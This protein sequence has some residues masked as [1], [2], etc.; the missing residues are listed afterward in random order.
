MISGSLWKGILLF[1]L[2]LMA[3]NLLQVLFNISDIAV[4]GHFAGSKAL[5]EVGSTTTLVTLFLGI[6]LGLGNGVNVWVA[7]YLGSK[8]D[9][10]VSKTIHTA[11]II[12]LF[13][14]VLLSLVGILITNPLLELLNTKDSLIDGAASY[15]KIYLLAMPALA[16]YNFGNATYS[17]YGNTKS[18]LIILSLS[19]LLNVVL[20]IIFVVAFNLDVVGVSLASVISSYLS[21]AIILLSLFKEKGKIRI[22]LKNLKID[23]NIANKI[24]SVGIPASLQY[25]TF[26]VA[27]LFIQSGVNSFDDVFVEG[28]SAAANADSLVYDI[29]ASFYV[30]SSSFISQNFGAGNKDRIKKTYLITTIYSFGIG[31]ILGLLLVFF[32]KYFLMIFTLDKEVINE[33]YKRL[34]I[35]G[36]C[37]AFSALMDNTT[38]SCRGLGKTLFPSI[39]ILITSCLFRM[40]WVYTIFKI[41][42]TIESLYLVY[43]F[44]WLLSA[45]LEIP[46]F[47]YIYKK[48]TKNINNKMLLQ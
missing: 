45:L 20:N 28:N 29:M 16:L 10:M 37:Y 43:I 4:V 38:A 27:N 22:N 14:G 7:R 1:S 35:M 9:E 18:P 17:A 44:S 11:F 24:L 31:L 30:A 32:G 36:L 2:P 41:F 3:S 5:G 15:L 34:F 40:I 47:I 26:A 39:A 8:E 23:Y 42:N 21:A 19:G 13:A 46:Y 48:S 12:C 33:G 25:A 6:V